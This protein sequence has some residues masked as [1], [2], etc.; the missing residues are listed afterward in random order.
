[1]KFSPTSHDIM[2]IWNKTK[3]FKNKMMKNFFSTRED[4]TGVTGSFNRL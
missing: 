3:F 2:I 4:K 1:M